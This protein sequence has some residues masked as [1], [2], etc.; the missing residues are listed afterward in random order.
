M[1]TETPTLKIDRQSRQ[2]SLTTVRPKEVK[3][4]LLNSG[5]PLTCSDLT[6]AV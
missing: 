1:L 4:V 6:N 3:E 2:I 5:L